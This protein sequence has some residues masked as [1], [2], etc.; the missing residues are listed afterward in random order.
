MKMVSLLLPLLFLHLEI[1]CSVVSTAKDDDCGGVGLGCF[2]KETTIPQ[3]ILVDYCNYV[4]KFDTAVSVTP[5]NSIYSRIQPCLSCDM[6]LLTADSNQT[7]TAVFYSLGLNGQTSGKCERIRV[8]IF[9]G[10]TPSND[11]LLSNT[12]G[13]CGSDLPN[14]SFETT[15]NTLTIRLTT[16]CPGSRQFGTFKIIVAATEKASDICRGQ[17][18]CRTGQCIDK[19]FV[20]DGYPQCP[21]NSDEAGCTGHHHHHGIPIWLI[22]IFVIIAVALFVLFLV[23]M[24]LACLKYA[25]HRGYTRV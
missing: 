13:I 17:F 25:C 1:I 3:A 22:L 18:E 12:N 24:A 15:N 6:K 7:V 23:T 21:D 20:C 19:N 14:Q 9:D 11:T 8:D 5:T 2:P 4:Y 16:S 10:W